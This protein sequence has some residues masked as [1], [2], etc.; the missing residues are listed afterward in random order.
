MICICAFVA[1][2]REVRQRVKDVIHEDQLLIVHVTAPLDVCRARDPHGLYEKADAGDLANFPGV[3]SAYE[4]P[5]D[6]DLVLHTDQ[7]DVDQ[8]VDEIMQLLRSQR[9]VCLV[10]LAMLQ[11]GTAS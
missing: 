5:I 11:A 4:P 7:I 1:P 6:P 9:S 3:S 10:N 2:N 8:C